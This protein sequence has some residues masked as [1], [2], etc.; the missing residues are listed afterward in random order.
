MT[1]PLFAGLS[2]REWFELNASAPV[3][4]D[5][6]DAAPGL[7]LVPADAEQ[8]RFT[9]LTGTANLSQAFSFY[10]FCRNLAHESGPLEPD[11]RILDFGCGWGRVARFWLRDVAPAS[12]WCVDVLATAVELMRQT[13]IPA[14]VLGCRP[15]PP[16]DG[17][18]AGFRIIHAYSVFSHLSEDAAHRW[19]AYLGGLL[20]PGGL[21]VVTTRGR[22]FIDALRAIREDPPDDFY[23]QRLAERAPSQEELE[24]MYA[25]GEFV[26]FAVG[27]AGSELSDDFYG[28]AV[29]PPG[30]ARRFERYG[31]TLREFREDVPEVEQ[32]V[33]VLER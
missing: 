13:R 31:L 12:L 5:E 18:P 28:E 27:H 20:E 11:D 1:Q 3:V 9:S 14:N 21:L 10:G 25:A 23:R 26:Y 2:D 22:I 7:P 24:R 30:Y 32:A 15:L 33:I 8:L 17:L 16:V 19:I 6:R 29:I 4:G